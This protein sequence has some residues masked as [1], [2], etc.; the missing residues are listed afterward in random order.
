MTKLLPSFWLVSVV[1][2]MCLSGFITVQNL[3]AQVYGM[4]GGWHKSF[5]D[6]I[7]TDPAGIYTSFMFVTIFGFAFYVLARVAMRYH[8]LTRN[9]VMIILI[10]I[11]LFVF[12]MD[13]FE[14]F[15]PQS[16]ATVNKV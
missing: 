13:Y 3:A 16:W 7:W 9:H 12:F 11:I 6:V 8:I 15:L 2:A 10:G 14:R 4:L 5:W 1:S